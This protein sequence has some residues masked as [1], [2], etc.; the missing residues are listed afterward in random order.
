MLRLL[1]F[2]VN[3]GDVVI[4]KLRIT[5]WRVIHALLRT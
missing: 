5:A 1:D 4:K 3:W 2:K